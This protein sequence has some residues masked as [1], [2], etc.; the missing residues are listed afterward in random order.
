MEGYL[1]IKQVAEKWNISPR[2]VQVLCSSGRIQGAVKFGRDWAI[3]T[4]AEK[5]PDEYK[6]NS[7]GYLYLRLLYT[8]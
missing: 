8:R 3:P 6:A 4:L 1:T 5:P 7:E 2:R